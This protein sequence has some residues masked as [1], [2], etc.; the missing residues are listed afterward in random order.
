MKQFYFN[1]NNIYSFYQLTKFEAFKDLEN[2][3]IVNN[4]ICN[5]SQLIKYFLGYRLEGLKKYNH[6]NI[7][8]EIKIMSK[9]IFQMFDISILEKEKT[10]EKE[11]NFENE[12]N[13]W[14]GDKSFNSNIL[15]YDNNDDK[16]HLWNYIK[17]NLPSAIF[18]AINE[19]EENDE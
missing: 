7:D 3:Q 12:K 19:L 2:I 1:S 15:L 5:S 18:A 14:N 6:E 16:I 13:N 11:S 9:N 8:D 10:I 4:E 17:Q